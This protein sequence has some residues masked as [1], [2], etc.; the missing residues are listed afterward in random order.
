MKLNQTV[1]YKQFKKIMKDFCLLWKAL[2]KFNTDNGFFLS[3]GL[4]FNIL[5]SLIPLILLLLAL[6]GI[7]LHDEQRV[8]N[9]IRDYLAHLAPTLDP[10][11]MENLSDVT[12]KRHVLGV[13]GFAG[14]IFT[15]TYVFSSMRAA[16]QIVFKVEKARSLLAG[17][18]LDMFMILLIG[19]LLLLSML[20]TYVFTFVKNAGW[21][22]ALGSAIQWL[23]KYLIPFLFTYLMFFLIYKIV[24]K[25]KIHYKCALQAALVAA[26]LWEGAKH[27]FGWYVNHLNNY[28]I[29]YGS[30][31]TL[32]IFILWVYYS[33]A[34]LIMGGEFVYFLE[35]DLSGM[36]PKNQA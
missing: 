19:L 3:S 34:I 29:F 6:A 31:S 36:E 5:V 15:A 27:L 30:F 23:L 24:P 35:N 17:L 2:K 10:K 1:K 25:I 9:Q 14:L 13:I 33:S 22:V 11:I 12:Q 16:F 20:L 32:I 18:M 21:M 7:Y 8:F 28:S 4:A 26:L